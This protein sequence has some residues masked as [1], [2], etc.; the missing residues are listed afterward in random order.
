MDAQDRAFAVRYMNNAHT[1]KEELPW[2][3]IRLAMASVA[4]LAVTPMQE[5]LCLGGEA[6]INKP[7]TLGE[8]WKWRLFRDRLPMK[9]WKKCMK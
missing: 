6:R 4:D 2:D 1:E 7:S 5:F 9:F 8:N 3:F